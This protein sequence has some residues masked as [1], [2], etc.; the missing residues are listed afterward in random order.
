MMAKGVATRRYAR[1]ASKVAEKA[2]SQLG[3]DAQR[4]IDQAQ[5][6]ARR[7]NDNHIGTEHIVQGVME[8]APAM[9]SL[10]EDIGITR[11]TFQAQ[12]FDEPGSSPAGEIPLTPRTQQILGFALR[13]ATKRCSP[14]IE[15]THLLLGVIDESEHWRSIRPDGPHHLAQAAESIGLRLR[16]VRKAI[17]D[18]TN[19]SSNARRPPG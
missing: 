6:A 17:E 3:P 2:A 7:S 16:E 13:Q 15:P 18:S 10:L 9:R 5:V 4:C 11:S 8:A 14:M 1:E 12:L 19:S